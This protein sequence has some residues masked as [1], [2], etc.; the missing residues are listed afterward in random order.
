MIK[1][2]LTVVADDTPL[3]RCIVWW[4]VAGVLQGLGFVLLVP[5]LSALLDGDTGTAAW[6]SL[7]M[8]GVLVVYAAVRYVAQLA[9]YRAA[10]GLSKGLF[11]K[12]GDK[13]AV[14]PL[15]WFHGDRVG[16]LG[17]LTS[18]GV[19][20]VMGVPAHMLRPIITAFVT[21]A[22]LLVALVFFDWR[23]AL[24]TLAAVPFAFAAFRWTQS[25]VRKA[26][27][28]H[29][30]AAAEAGSRLVEFG[31][32]QAVLRAYGRNVD[33]NQILDDAL[34]GYRDAGR[35]LLT[36]AVP[37]LAGFVTVIQMAFTA[38]LF[39]GVAI[40]T[41]GSLDAPELIAILVLIVRFVEPLLVAADI[42]GA[43]KMADATLDRADRLLNEPL[44]PEP[45]TDDQR[46]LASGSLS[47]DLDAVG[48]GYDDERR[49]I[50]DLSLDVPA[51]SMTALVGPS[52]SGK[53]TVARLVA[54]FWDV[55]EGAVRVDGTDVRDVPTEHLMSKVSIVFQ[56]TYLFAGTIADNLRLAKPDATG[57]ELAEVAR[58]ARLDE[59]LER[60]PGG[61]DAEVG[62]GGTRLSG[63]E[64]Q[65]VSIARALL[66]D[67]PIVLLDE[68]TA[69][70][71]PL[72]EVAIQNAIDTLRGDR[73]I[74]VIAHRL[75]TVVGADQI[76][77]L[78]DGRVG[79]RG[80]HDELLEHGGRYADFW[81]ERERAV[82]WRISSGVGR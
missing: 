66:K 31:Q 75:Q 46:T 29:H 61:W 41:G 36:T 3:R 21:P 25:L 4:V 53:T 22:T 28:A 24:A 60:L 1:R 79:E 80:T 49:V 5:V 37:G 72:N 34:S 15:G 39:V 17:R 47:V 64:R 9:S 7:A 67:A 77:V 69:A 20:D 56:E 42:G 59:M 11:Q 10:I 14:L 38:L 12:L 71:D 51:G 18:K 57:D 26:D 78:D 27:G 45:A 54:R 76:V 70:I 30:D 65:R 50:H 13:V 68:A 35:N 8:V 62:E 23:L 82:G 6:W 16:P 73:T 33:G 44:L 81:R 63:G 74:I 32:T 2:L 55:D 52:G 58:L 48:F 43:M 40:A 19:I